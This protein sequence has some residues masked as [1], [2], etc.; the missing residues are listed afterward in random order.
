MIGKTE[1]EKMLKAHSIGPRMISYLEKIGVETLSELRGADPQELAMRIDIA[2]GRK[3]M[4]RLGVEAL[5][6]LVELAER[7]G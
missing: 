4:N 1:R 6:N 7:E 2:L 5:R 3:H